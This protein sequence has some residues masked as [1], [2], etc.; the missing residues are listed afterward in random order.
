MSPF[1]LWWL[2]IGSTEMP[3]ILAPRLAN[4]GAMPGHVAELG[5]A[6]RREVLRVA[7]QDR[8]SVADPLVE[9]DRALGGVGR[10]VGG[11]VVDSAGSFRFPPLHAARAPPRGMRLTATTQARPL[12]PRERRRRRGGGIDFAAAAAKLCRHRITRGAPCPSACISCS[13]ASS[14]IRSA[15]SSATSRTSTSSGSFPTTP[16]PTSAWKAKAQA[17]VDNAHARYFIAHLHRLRD[18]ERAAGPTEELG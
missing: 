16:P 3:R 11:D 17:T 9:R 4:S 6:D 2:S 15:P 10:E 12:S 7:E 8:P 13:A 14:S 18:E 5:G 1:H